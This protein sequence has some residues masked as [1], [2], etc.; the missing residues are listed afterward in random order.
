M[1]HIKAAANTISGDLLSHLRASL[2]WVRHA[3]EYMHCTLLEAY[4]TSMSLLDAH[5]PATASLSSHHNAM[6][7]F[8]HALAVDAASWALHSGDVCRAIELL[9]QGRT[10]IWMQMVQFRTPLDSLQEDNHAKAVTKKFRDL[11]SL[12]DNPL[13]NHSEGTQKVNA[14]TEA[15]R[16][17]HLVE[18]WNT[19]VEETRKL[20][21][22][23]CFLL[24]P[25]FS[26]LQ[27]A[28]CGGPIIVLIASKSYCHAVI[29]LHQ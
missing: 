12:L 6:M 21:G 22:L 11:S 3:E 1:H 9:E 19:T 16:Y 29:V 20:K 28:A 27:D 23:S 13:A 24:P 14:E 25:L 18:D 26:E 17:T 8:P 4:A 10:L 7:A 15:T 5:M 2:S